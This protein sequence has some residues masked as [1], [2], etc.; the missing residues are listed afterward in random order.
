MSYPMTPKQMHENRGLST[1]GL[2]AI[3]V[4]RFNMADFLAIEFVLLFVV[5]FLSNIG[6]IPSAFTYV[7]DIV[8]LCILLSNARLIGK[9]VGNEPFFNV[10]VAL[11]AVMA[12]LSGIIN[13]IAPQYIIWQAISFSR[14]FVWIYLFRIFGTKTILGLSWGSSTKCRCQTSSSF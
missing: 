14:L 7:F 5:N 8:N 4:H 3:L 13:T 2:G 9:R 12:P 6:L 10:P 11:F 1:S